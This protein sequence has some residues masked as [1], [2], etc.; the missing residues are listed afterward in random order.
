MQDLYD[1][2][3][4]FY[5]RHPISAD[6]IVAKLREERGNL[7]HVRPEELYPHDQDHYG[8]LEANDA[9]AA[10]TGMDT[11]DRVADFCAGLGGPARYWASTRGVEVTGVDLSP[12][13][14]EGAAR[15]NRLVGLDS[16]VTVI[17]GN[18]QDAPLPSDHFDAVVSQ[19]AFLHLPDKARAVA[20]AFR[21]LKPGGRFAFTDWIVHTA[22]PTE[23]A[24]LLLEGMSAQTLQSIDSY[25]QTLADAGFVDISS[26]DLTTAW[27]DILEKR[28]AMY[29]ALREDAAR[30]GSPSGDESFYRSY[31]TLVEDVK[32]GV[33]GGARLAGRKPA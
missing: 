22:L 1:S 15:L 6:H 27:A 4:A 11:G 23:D 28:F 30:T 32:A 12:N 14:V 13:R 25:R 2:V 5:Q 3:R 17:A 26:E 20:E 33:M 29:R 16:R 18:V 19:E 7:D 24:A 9:L 10:L 21:V 8:G 31:V